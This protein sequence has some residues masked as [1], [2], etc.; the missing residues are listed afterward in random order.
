M[1]RF[2]VSFYV[3]GAFAKTDF[4]KIELN[5]CLRFLVLLGSLFLAEKTSLHKCVF[6]EKKMPFVGS[7]NKKSGGVND[8]PLGRKNVRIGLFCNKSCF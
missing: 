6:E 7:N 8:S 4:K 1:E 3:F 5:W 2:D